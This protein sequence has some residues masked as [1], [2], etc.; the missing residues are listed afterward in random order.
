MLLFHCKTEVRNKRFTALRWTYCIW[1][2]LIRIGWNYYTYF[3]GRLCRMMN[4][5]TG[6]CTLKW[7]PACPSTTYQQQRGGVPFAWW[8]K[9]PIIDRHQSIWHLRVEPDELMPSRNLWRDI[10]LAW[11]IATNIIKTFDLIVIFL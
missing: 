10:E 3:L 9:L 4:K 6:Q 7:N 11:K 5:E 1:K 8:E 2:S